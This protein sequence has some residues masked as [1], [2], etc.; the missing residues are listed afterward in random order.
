MQEFLLSSPDVIT[1]RDS[2]HV[3]RAIALCHVEGTLRN[4]E[5]YLDD[6]AL[7]ERHRAPR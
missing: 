2:T 7:V 4:F 6:T 5:Q 3:A 1:D